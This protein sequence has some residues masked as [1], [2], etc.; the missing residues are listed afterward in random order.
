M[1]YFVVRS[2]EHCEIMAGMLT[3]QDVVFL[4]MSMRVCIL[5]SVGTFS[6]FLLC[7]TFHFVLVGFSLVKNS[8]SF[9]F[10]VFA[11]LYARSAICFASVFV[12]RFVDANP[13]PPF[14][15]ILMQNPAS[16]VDA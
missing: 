5:S 13:M 2:I 4:L 15:I 8:F 16:T 9:L 3:P 7:V 14:A 1:K 6:I 12:Q 10:A 11:Y